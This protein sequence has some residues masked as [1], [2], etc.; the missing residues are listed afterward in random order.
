MGNYISTSIIFTEILCSLYYQH[1]EREG[2][3]EEEVRG[4]KIKE[5][6]GQLRE[7][8]RYIGDR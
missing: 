5:T 6:E 3:R 8:Q 1:E 7:I 2:G 4:E